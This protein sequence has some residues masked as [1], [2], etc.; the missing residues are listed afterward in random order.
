MNAHYL[1]KYFII[2][3]VLTL[4]FVVYSFSSVDLY[5]VRSSYRN[6][7][8]VIYLSEIEPKMKSQ[9]PYQG[10]TFYFL[11]PS[12]WLLGQK[13]NP[14]CSV[15]SLSTMWQNII[16]SDYIFV[17]QNNMEYSKTWTII[18]GTMAGWKESFPSSVWAGL[19]LRI[20]HIKGEVIFQV[21]IHRFHFLI[22][23]ALY[24]FTPD[25]LNCGLSGSKWCKGNILFH[26]YILCTYHF[27]MRIWGKKKVCFFFQFMSIF[28][29][30]LEKNNWKGWSWKYKHH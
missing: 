17:Q 27:L 20:Y 6:S 5:N 16:L 19:P 12:K 26:Y 10:K 3:A 13:N 21:F 18:L 23:L 24:H 1:L 4:Q 15:I 7:V 25:Y 22:C 8:F 30:M 14:V 9:V 29:A 11:F 28:A 2:A